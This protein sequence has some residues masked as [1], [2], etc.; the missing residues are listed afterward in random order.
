MDC[1]GPCPAC[2]GGRSC[3]RNS[4]CASGACRNGRCLRASCTDSVLN[5]KESDVDCGDMENC[6]IPCEEGAACKADAQCS[7]G[8]VCVSGMCATER[9]ST[10][11]TLFTD[12]A[13]KAQDGALNVGYTV[14]M[15]SMLPPT[16]P[17]AR[18]AAIPDD[19]SSVIPPPP[20]QPAASPSPVSL[21]RGVFQ[22]AGPVIVVHEGAGAADVPVLREQGTFGNA[23]V[24]YRTV[25]GG[26]AR[27]SDYE[28]VEGV[29]SFIAGTR[30][31]SFSITVFDD[32]VYSGNRTVLLELHSPAGGATLHPD[33]S[34]ALLVILD[35]DAADAPGRVRSEDGVVIALAL[36]AAVVVLAACVTGFVWRRRRDNRAR[37]VVQSKVPQST[38]VFERSAHFPAAGVD[39]EAGQA[40][41]IA[42]SREHAGNGEAESDAFGTPH[43][44]APATASATPAASN[45]PAAN[46]VRAAER[47]QHSPTRSPALPR[48][49]RQVLP[50]E[51]EASAQQQVNARSP[52]PEGARPHPV[53]WRTTEK[54]RAAHE[55]RVRQLQE[56]A[57]A[58]EQS[59]GE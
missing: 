45:V 20:R 33:L 10:M 48:N 22:F 53:L 54:W 16:A 19:S 3:S 28:A 23:G 26:S 41:P 25:P 27:R 59:N 4:H 29:L 2:S 42:E 1:G 57:A 9:F 24:S 8:H 58:E 31:L 51:A 13:E 17:A 12:I 44:G 49:R 11:A 46:A 35:D 47:Y 32:D 39:P 5:G 37:K 30:R 15:L 14:D 21:G 50:G 38:V 40:A 6:G 7:R 55:M 52:A 43:G 18:A 36:C 34:N 56:R